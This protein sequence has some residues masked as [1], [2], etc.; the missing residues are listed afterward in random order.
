MLANI[1]RQ[2]AAKRASL[3]DLAILAQDA[4]HISESYP[5]EIPQTAVVAFLKKH[6]EQSSLLRRVFEEDDSER[7][8]KI[9]ALQ[10]KL[11]K[12]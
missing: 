4:L 8:G 7:H 12:S 9:A 5:D 3:H 1:K 11:H 6:P 10:K 2:L